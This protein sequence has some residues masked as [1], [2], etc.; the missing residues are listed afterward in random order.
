MFAKLISLEY[1]GEDSFCDVKPTPRELK[2][3]R[4]N[5]LANRRRIRH[6][7]SRIDFIESVMDKGELTEIFPL[8]EDELDSE[9]LSAVDIYC[10]NCGHK[11]ELSGANCR[12]CSNCFEGGVCG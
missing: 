12:K 5:V 10:I 7:Q 2:E 1:L 6:F 3:L 8:Y 9:E 11:T 4:S